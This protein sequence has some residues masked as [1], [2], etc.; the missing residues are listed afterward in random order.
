[1]FNC[2][3]KVERNRWTEYQCNVRTINIAVVWL[4]ALSWIFLSSHC[5]IGAMPGFEFLQ[6]A[7]DAQAAHEEGDPCQNEGCCAAESAQYQ[8][9]RQQENAPVVILAI[10]P[11]GNLGLVEESLPEE[12]SLGVLTAAPP[13]L[14]TCWQFSLRAALPVRAPSLAS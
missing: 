3:F 8:A 1:M 7:A 13:E 12:V 2:R 10:A 5:R 11:G 9:P 14:P 6:C 4:L